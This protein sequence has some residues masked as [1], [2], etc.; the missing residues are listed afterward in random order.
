MYFATGH[1]PADQAD[2]FSTSSATELEEHNP[3]THKLVVDSAAEGNKINKNDGTYKE[4]SVVSVNL[5]AT[6]TRN[7]C[8]VT[9]PSRLIEEIESSMVEKIMAVEAGIEGGF[10]HT[11]ELRPM[12]YEE[13]M[14]I[15]K[16]KQWSVL[17]M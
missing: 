5:G 6:Q 8:T 2:N 17:L 13:A 4:D 15:P 3:N 11:S 7:G 10:N 12:K 14:A 9:T 1:D 16:A